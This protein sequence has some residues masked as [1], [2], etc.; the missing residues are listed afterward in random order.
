MLTLQ[1]AMI[2][3]QRSKYSEAES[4]GHTGYLSKQSCLGWG[5][6]EQ[7]A[8]VLA[9]IHPPATIKPLHCAHFKASSVHKGDSGEIPPFFMQPLLQNGVFIQVKAREKPVVP[10]VKTE[11]L[12]RQLKPRDHSQTSKDLMKIP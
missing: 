2:K 12:P 11:R 3:V 5:S 8:I 9:P 1:L 6:K 4:H 10:R 7:G